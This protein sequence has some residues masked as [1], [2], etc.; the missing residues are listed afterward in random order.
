MIATPILQR[1]SSASTSASHILPVTTPPRVTSTNTPVFA[2]PP[3]QATLQTIRT[4]DASVNTETQ[5]SP[6]AKA[7]IEMSKSLVEAL[8]RQTFQLEMTKNTLSAFL[9]RLDDRDRERKSPANTEIDN[10]HMSHDMRFPTMCNFDKCRLRRA[11]AAS[12]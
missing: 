3:A 1:P 11:C 10:S 8:E 4:T 12:F 9:R 6:V 2:T 7:I 5:D